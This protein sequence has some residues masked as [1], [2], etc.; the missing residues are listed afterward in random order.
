VSIVVLFAL[1][2]ALGSMRVLGFFAVGA[3]FGFGSRLAVLFGSRLAVIMIAALRVETSF[4][5]LQNPFSSNQ[6][7]A[8][9]PIE[10][11][12]QR[13]QK[14]RRILQKMETSPNRN[15]GQAWRI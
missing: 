6:R 14:Y 8:A 13:P 7:Y 2:A 4:F 12:W 10:P 9:R 5:I 3:R 1:T 15:S 11:A